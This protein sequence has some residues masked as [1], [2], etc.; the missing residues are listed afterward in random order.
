MARQLPDRG[1]G[2][3][4]CC[5]RPARR[6]WNEAKGTDT[7]TIQDVASIGTLVLL[8]GLLSADNALVLALIARRLPN[9][10]D[11]SRALTLGI[12]LSFVFRAIGLFL[13]SFIIKFWYLRA[14]G[15]GYLLYLA[16]SH[17]ISAARG[18]GHGHDEEE[19]ENAAEA[20][21]PNLDGTDLEVAAAVSA[22]PTPWLN[23]GPPPAD[24]KAFGKVV[25][26]LALTDVAF[27]IDSIL[28]AVALT[29]NLW[30]IYAGVALGIIALRLVADAF[31][32]LLERYP[33]LDHT[34]YALVAWA[35]IKLGLE[36]ISS[37]GASVLGVE[38]HLELPKSMFWFGMAVITAI[39]TLVAIRRPA[40][41][42]KEG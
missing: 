26:A 10:A 17:F 15:A 11:R 27:A 36:A 22:A 31:M 40:P 30:V 1:R 6:G 29:N 3:F 35:G 38:W 16:I 4:T 9:K 13:A 14:L 34:A 5:P 8:E 37:F 42:A 20:T 21:P 23:E 12:T 32:R 39:G 18:R 25:V 19:S 24:K 28:V 33:A 2:F 41:V 7:L